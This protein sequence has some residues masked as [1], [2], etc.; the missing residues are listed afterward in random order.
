MSLFGV[1]KRCFHHGFRHVFRERFREH[2]R[3]HFRAGFRDKFRPNFRDGFRVSFRAS[4]RVTFRSQFRT[5]FRDKF[6]EHF[7]DSLHV[8][9]LRIF[10]ASC[11][12]PLTQNMTYAR[13]IL[14]A[15]L[16]IQFCSK[17]KSRFAS[18]F[19][20]ATVAVPTPF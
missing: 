15:K 20:C 13:V 7:R 6:R 1:K 12:L 2:P 14:V 19:L 3:A 17:P 8:I 10:R 4:F 5:S 18:H 9:F 16:Q 11:M